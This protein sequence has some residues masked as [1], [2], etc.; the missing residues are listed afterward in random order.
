MNEHLKHGNWCIT[1]RVSL[2]CGPE[3]NITI[4]K[5]IRCPDCGRRLKPH[6]YDCEDMMSD[7]HKLGECV[8]VCVPPHKK[9]G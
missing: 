1:E 3:E 9:R 7:G 8:H 6:T 2:F 4:P 5:Y